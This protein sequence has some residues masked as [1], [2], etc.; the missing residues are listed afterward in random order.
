MPNSATLYRANMLPGNDLGNATAETQFKNGRGA[1]LS[2]ALPSN[3]SL[4]NK[5]FRV[6][7]SGRVATTSN[8]TFTVSLYFGLSST[9]ASNTLLYTTNAVV[10]NNVSSNWEFWADCFWSTNGTITGRAEGQIA[11]QIF[12]PGTLANT[13]NADPNRDSNTFLQSGATYAFTVTGQ[14]SGSSTGNHAFIDDLS[15][16]V[17]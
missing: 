9:I 13:P 8:L 6:R 16:E 10:V 14:F 2:L 15:L 17:V 1:Q 7:I 4:T 11:N 12:G 5:S 3:N